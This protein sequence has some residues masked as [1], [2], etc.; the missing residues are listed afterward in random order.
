MKMAMLKLMVLQ[1]R[2]TQISSSDEQSIDAKE[3]GKFS[4]SFKLKDKNDSK[5]RLDLKKW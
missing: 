1:K 2:G 5:I 3:D 4:M